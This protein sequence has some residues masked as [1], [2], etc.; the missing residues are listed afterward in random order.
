[1]SLKFYDPYIGI[2]P[3][4]PLTGKKITSLIPFDEPK[5][6]RISKK[7]IPSSCSETRARIEREFSGSI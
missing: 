3:K 1:M 7:N 5:K 2:L 6:E 4:F